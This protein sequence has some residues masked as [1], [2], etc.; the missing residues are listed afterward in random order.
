M[1]ID[2]FA[3]GK[4]VGLDHGGKH[5]KTAP[6]GTC[7]THSKTKTCESAME[8]FGI[9]TQTKTTKNKNKKQKQN[10]SFIPILGVERCVKVVG[11]N[12]SDLHLLSRTDLFQGTHTHTHT[13]TH[14]QVTKK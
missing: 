3:F 2:T 6:D 9:H 4:K 5:R 10:S 8:N 7:S 12:A 14:T 11:V 1:G 13:H